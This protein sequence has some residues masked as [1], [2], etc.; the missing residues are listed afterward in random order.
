MQITGHKT[1]RAF[2]KYIRLTNDHAISFAE[3]YLRQENKLKAV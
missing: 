3:Q 1:E 2:M